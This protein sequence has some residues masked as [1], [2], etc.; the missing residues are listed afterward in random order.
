MHIDE[1]LGVLRVINARS[2]STKRGGFVLPREGLEAMCEASTSGV[3]IL[4]QQ[5]LAWLKWDIRTTLFL[6]RLRARSV[7]QPRPCSIKPM[8][9]DPVC[10]WI[11]SLPSHINMMFQSS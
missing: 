10:H 4:G 6:T 7:L 2:F 9:R 8:E 11:S 3:P 5:G 1:R